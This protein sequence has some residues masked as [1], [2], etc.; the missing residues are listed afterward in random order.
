MTDASKSNLVEPAVQSYGR[1][2]LMLTQAFL[3]CCQSNP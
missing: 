1:D 3:Q 2:D